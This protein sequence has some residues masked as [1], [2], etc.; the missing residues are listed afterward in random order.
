MLTIE[1]ELKRPGHSYS[2]LFE[3]GLCADWRREVTQRV[4]AGTYLALVDANLARKGLAPVPPHGAADGAWR[5]LW[6]E[7]GEEHKNLAHYAE[8]CEGAL[9]FGIDRKTVV[10]AVGGGVTGDIAGFVAATLLRGL[11]LVQIPTTL[12]A[13]VD[14]SVGG[15]NGVNVAVGKNLVGT[16]LQPELVLVD[17]VFLDS[18]PEREYRAGVAEV[19]KT[20]VLD[21]REFF[22]ELERSQDR[23][24]ER[25]HGFLSE[26]I[27][28]CCRVKTGYVMADELDTGKR[29]LLNLG[30]T[31]GH[32]LE[33]LAG[34][35]GRVVHGEAVA[36]GMVLACDFSVKRGTMPVA[37]ANAVRELLSRLGLPVTIAELGKSS[38]AETGIGMP[39]RDLLAGKEGER[40]L[41]MDKKADGGK[42]NL[43]LP[44]AIGDCR[45]EKGFDAG[46]VMDFMRANN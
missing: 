24:R 2:I 40:A 33:A 38:G 45:F 32:A 8:L 3:P 10:V 31:F 36:V 17:P 1:A 19:V 26:A 41:F 7:P 14:S 4:P 42:V 5:Y 6:V 16:F 18:L 11:R 9:R 39:W 46:A 37:D 30:H 34:Y 43:V 21:G 23:L 27:A 29:Q 25:D 28:R 12:L 35:D 13:Q 20:A 22:S 15:K 44:H